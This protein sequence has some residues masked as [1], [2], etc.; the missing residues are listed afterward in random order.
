MATTTSKN[1]QPAKRAIN[2]DLNIKAL[3]ENYSITNPQ[4]AYKEIRSFF[5]KNGFFHRQGSGY[6]SHKMMT[7]AQVVKILRDMN[8]AFPWLDKCSKKID[9]TDIGEIYD[10]K[11]FIN[12][13]NIKNKFHE[14]QKYRHRQK[15][16]R[17]SV[18]KKLDD[19]KKFLKEQNAYGDKIKQR[20]ECNREVK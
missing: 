20:G 11:E 16:N 4:G 15:S 12:Q 5:E 3:K 14:K 7:N 9:I 18:L 6:C 8:K 1:E 10:A 19:N 13:N 2:F 17:A